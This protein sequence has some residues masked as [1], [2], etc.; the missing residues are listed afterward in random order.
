MAFNRGAVLKKLTLQWDFRQV[1]TGFCSGFLS[2]LELKC[3]DARE[4]Q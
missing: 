3:F 1:E 4:G 2:D